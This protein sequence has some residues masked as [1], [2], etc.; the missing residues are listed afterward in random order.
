M[1]LRMFTRE[2][3]PMGLGNFVLVGLLVSAGLFVAS[4][5]IFAAAA[6]IDALR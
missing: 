3:D 6:A 1:R 5:L 2:H 4:L